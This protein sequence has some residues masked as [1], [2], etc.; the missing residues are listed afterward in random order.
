M[1]ENFYRNT[2]NGVFIF[3]VLFSI[4]TISLS[5]Q[6]AQGYVYEDLNQNSIKDANEKGIAKVAVSNGV[7]VVLTD[8]KGKYSLPISDDNII[9]VIKPTGYTFPVNEYQQPQ[10]YY[11]HKPK[12]SPKTFYT[13]VKPTPEMP[14]SL[15][16]AMMSHEE[17][18][19]Y[20]ILV[21]GDPQPYTLTQVDYFRRG[22][23]AELAG[24][25]DYEFG[26]SLGDL[27]G[28]R[29]G[30]FYPYLYSIAQVGLPWYH[31]YGNHDMNY[32]VEEDHLAD[33]TFESV[34]GPA[35]YSFNYGKVHYLIMD[36]V[37]YPDPRDGKGYWG[38]FR[39]DQI[40]FMKNDLKHVPKDYL[41]VVNFHIPLIEPDGGDYFRDEDRIALFDMLKSFSNTLSMSAH[42]HLQSHEFYGEEDGWKGKGIHHHYNV[43]TT[44]G[45]WYSGTLDEE[46][47]P[48][49]MM[50]DGTPKGYAELEIKGNQY[51]F[52]Y[53]VVGK[54]WDHKMY[55]HLPKIVPH[56][57]SYRGDIVVNFFQGTSKD[58]LFFRVDGGE[59]EPMQYKLMSDPALSKTHF[60][61]DYSYTLPS[62]RR[63]S[64][65]VPSTHIWRA[66]I[67][68]KLPVGEHKVDVKA[69]DFMG[70]SYIQSSSYIIK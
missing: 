63:P 6:T 46:G 55:I 65:P 70:R 8:S 33:E 5:G 69:V 48:N 7:D 4:L 26:I 23:V 10:S 28:D 52:D 57:V 27:V 62:G 40:E 17:K 22:V 45:D 30:L 60:D 3:T 37:L 18:D 49:A 64:F 61:W 31:V 34:F 2:K 54:D 58:S 67:T 59:W 41:V 29:L 36:D 68:N 39:P 38:G 13:G 16:F 20:K 50:R 1:P 24:T 42:S 14:E 9:F 35:N 32:D 25:K 11:I 15:D 53:K 66:R 19:N 51:S 21:F 44:S 56:N 47:I 12:G 43:G